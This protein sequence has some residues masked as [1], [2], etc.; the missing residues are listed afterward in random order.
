MHRFGWYR[1][2]VLFSNFTNE[3]IGTVAH[4][5]CRLPCVF[6]RFESLII[7]LPQEEYVPVWYLLRITFYSNYLRWM[8]EFDKSRPLFSVNMKV[9][10]TGTSRCCVSGKIF[11]G[12]GSGFDVSSIQNS[13][14]DSTCIQKTY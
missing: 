1:F 6:S 7:L 13:D 8:P 9:L 2:K 10:W 4:I 5:L 11:F 3:K 14:L 12:S